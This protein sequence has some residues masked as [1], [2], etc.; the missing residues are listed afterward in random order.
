MIFRLKGKRYFDCPDKYGAFIKPHN[1]L[2]GDFPP[3]DYDL[4]E[5]I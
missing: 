3:E 4:N 1:V 5:E 2:C